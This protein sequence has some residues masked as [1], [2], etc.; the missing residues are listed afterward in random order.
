MLVAEL[1]LDIVASA[2]DLIGAPAGI[3]PGDGHAVFGQGAGL[4]RADH[5]GRTQG[6]RRR[7][8]ADQRLAAR[9]HHAGQGQDGGHQCRQHLGY[10]GNDQ[11]D[12]AQEAVG[13]VIT[14]VH[15]VAEIE[16]TDNQ[17]GDDEGLDEL[18]H[19]A[20]QRGHPLVGGRYHVGD[21]AEYRAGAGVYHDGSR[22]ALGEEGAGKPHVLPI[23]RHQV[24]AR[25]RVRQ[26]LHRHRLTGQGGLVDMDITDLEKAH[27]GGNLVAALHYHD[28]A[29]H[30]F[31]GGDAPLV[32]VA[33]YQAFLHH[34]VAEC[35]QRPLG[36]AFLDETEHR[37][38]QHHAGDDNGVGQH[39][40][41]QGGECAGDQRRGQQDDYHGVIELAQESQPGGG[42]LELQL[43]GAVLLEASGGNGFGEPGGAAVQGGQQLDTGL[44]VPRGFFHVRRVLSRKS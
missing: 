9:H 28:V 15:P 13:D 14:Q 32:P 24:F 30:Q 42:F 10:G 23:T 20:L 7:Q 33:Q 5:R 18:L 27:V 8:F 26:L 36:L 12:R 21:L 6:L 19:L 31:A 22:R 17:D 4:V 3:H 38:E 43:V 16:G 1:A 29:G 34:H 37:V 41:A 44:A 11:G 25:D 39:V 40:A 2:G 35:V